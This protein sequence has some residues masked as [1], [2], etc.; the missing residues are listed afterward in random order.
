[1]K[2]QVSTYKYLLYEVREQIAII[3]LNRPE[4]LNA[5]TQTFWKEI[6]QA[7][8]AGDQDSG[9]A[10]HVITG[11]G[12]AF[13]AGD[14]ISI[15]TKIQNPKDADELFLDCIYRLVDTIVHLKKP[16]ISAVNGLAYGGG[17]ELVFLSDLAVA[18]DKA[19][20]ALP[21][22]HIGAFPAI[23]TAL[24]PPVLG[25]KAVNELSM[26]GKP[27]AAKRACELGLV[28]LVVSH[29]R[30]LDT[31]LSWAEQCKK[32]SP[33]ALRIIKETSSKI[34]GDQLHSFWIG[35]HRFSREISRDADFLEG[36]AA[37]VEKRVPN[38]IR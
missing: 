11:K 21:E 24:G 12:R 35:C 16:L 15:L 26:L 31:A 4:K 5:L 28:N 34:L 22:G 30:V 3:T 10:V 25:H 14:D 1:M 19:T 29:D 37:F 13:C 20:F 17:C 32:S 8:Y 38:Y 2:D 7:L 27:I 33:G 9:V 18:S 36:T 23:L 6:R